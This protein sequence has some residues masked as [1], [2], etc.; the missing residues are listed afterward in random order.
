MSPW[1]QAV[2]ATY[3]YGTRPARA[4]RNWQAARAGRA[5]VMI[6]FYH[7]VADD[8]ANAWT[9]PEALFARQMIWMKRRF[10]MIS[11]AEAQQ[12]LREGNKR[13][14]VAVTFDDG[15]GENQALNEAE[16]E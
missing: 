2:L 10:D 5:P 4:W 7:R 1:K 13:P 11:L 9:C 12:R 15:Y 6:L 16:F 14:A 3:Y 8:R